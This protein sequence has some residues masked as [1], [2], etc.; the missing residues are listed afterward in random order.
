MTTPFRRAEILAVGSELLTP[1]RTDTNSLYLTARLNELGIEISGKSVVAD[2]R[3]ALESALRAALARAD[4]VVTT[5]GLGPTDDDMTRDAVAAV[6]GLTSTEDATVLAA[7]E[8]RFNTRGV[9]MPPVNRR[10]AQVPRGAQVLPNPRGT[11]PGLWLEIDGRVVVA[12]PGPPREL[13]PMYEDHV[14]PRLQARGRGVVLRRRVVKVAGRGESHVEELAQPVY[15]PWRDAN[16]AIS[17]TILASPGQVELHLS[18][19][20]EDAARLEAALEMAVAALQDVLGRNVVSVDG[21]SLEEVVGAL[22]LE[23]RLM[24]AA[25]ESCTGGLLLGAMTDVPGSS[26]WV[27]GGVVAYAN[28][29]KMQQLDVP[30]ELIAA[31]GAVSEPVAGAMAEGARRRLGAG[32]GVGI[33]GIAGPG[34]GTEAKPVGTVALAVAGP[35]DRLVVRTVRLPGDRT[36]VRQMAVQSALDLI[37]RVLTGADYN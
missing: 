37:R 1:F 29:I 27:A 2:D 16:P 36:M 31:H 3:A 18:V 12:L 30:A 5:G 17:T 9:P 23:R 20:G 14:R 6:A 15:A 11:A 19:Q 35:D 33:T 28:E 7:I 21:R 24:L 10:Q 25:A 26:R 13:R 4:I 34:G 32:I 8:A 22:L